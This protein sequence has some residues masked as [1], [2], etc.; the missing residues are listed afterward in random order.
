MTIRA[1]LVLADT[2]VALSL[3]QQAKSGPAFR[4][5]WFAIVGLLRSVGH[6]LSKVDSENDARISE[7]SAICWKEINLTKPEPAIFWGFIDS[8]R[9]R[10]LKN[11]EH[12][13]T[14][15][16]IIRTE[17]PNTVWALD[18]ANAGKATQ[19]VS[20]F[21]VPTSTPDRSVISI[22]SGGPFAGQPEAQVAAQAIAW[23]D[24][25]L[26]KVETLSSSKC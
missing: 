12:G 1:R 8:E 11:Y 20:V 10:F 25:Y 15:V 2:K 14:R 3:H 18:L 26:T 13:I 16:Q 21:G 5:S 9:N 24:A 6:V 7:A 4:A 23:W 22:L 17:D 19:L